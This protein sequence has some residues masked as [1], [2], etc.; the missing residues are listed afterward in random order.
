MSDPI[1]DKNEL[2]DAEAAKELVDLKFA[3]DQSAIV[4]IT[5]N[6]GKI[7]YVNDKFCA[8][9]KYSREELIG[10]DHRIINSGYHSKEFFRQLWKEIASGRVWRGEL[11]NRAKDGTFYWVDTTIVPF[12]GAAGKPLRYIAI[13]YEI[14][15]RKMAEEQL[16]RSQRMESIGTL[17]GGIAHDFN[18]I[19]SPILMAAGMLRTK[20]LDDDAKRWIELITENTERGAALVQQVLTFA[21]G[22]SGERISVQVKHILKDLLRVLE[23]ILPKSIAVERN[24]PPDLWT[25]T[26]DPT[27]MQQVFINLCINARDAMPQGGKLTIKAENIDVISDELRSIGLTENRYVKVVVSDTGMGM[28]DDVVQQIF[29]PFFTTKE[30]GK[31]TGLGLSTVITIVKDHNGVID[32]KSEPLKGSAFAVFLPAARSGE[33]E[34]D[35]QDEHETL[36]GGTETVLVV[37][38]EENIREAARSVLTH[39]GYTV[40]TAAGSTEALEIVGSNN[41]DLVVTD[42]SMP[43]M[44]GV[45]LIGEL[46]KMRPELKAIAMSGSIDDEISDR[47][48]EFGIT[49]R[50]SKPFL[51][52]TLIDEI[53]AVLK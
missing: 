25:I 19:L 2:T 41:V 33:T 52:E 38:D 31:G 51:P 1:S 23:E 27:Q 32:V 34:N 24:I 37:D 50:I 30:I 42:I 11:R 3:L 26:A 4:A 35:V 28:T 10:Q 22:M 47:M 7:N 13:R 45:S 18:N 29:D 8:I 15:K 12:L 6:A 17:A 14:T 43:G 9:S 44:D 40:L 53:S 49:S 36:K 48:N 39:F 5:D 46:K 21:R 20:P 16:L